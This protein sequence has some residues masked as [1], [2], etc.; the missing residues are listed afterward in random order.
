MK[1]LIIIG[2]GGFGRELLLWTAPLDGRD[3]K[4]GGF[5]DQKDS[6]LHD[7]DVE[8]PILGSP[9][10]YVPRPQDV[11][12][13]GLGLPE[14][15]RTVISALESRGARFV[16]IIHPTAIV[17][18]TSHIGE[19]SILCPYSVVTAN[20]TLGR[21]VTLN[22]SAT[23]GHDST[24]GDWTTLSCHTDVSGRC[25]IG[26]GVF[27]GSHAAVLPSRRVADDAVL[28]AGS[29]ITRHVESGATVCGVPAKVLIQRKKVSGARATE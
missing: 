7:M 13:C 3:W 26:A 11:F 22:L 2:A 27:F 23:V 21:F 25:V 29:V 20:V 10:T 24:I 18:A 17:G 9:D 5:L 28:G 19:G 16:T 4:I 14:V 1:R 8:Y 12:A 15:K 6:A